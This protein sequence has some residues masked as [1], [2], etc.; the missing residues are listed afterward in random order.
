MGEY[1]TIK[2]GMK[3]KLPTTAAAALQVKH[4]KHDHNDWATAFI[5]TIKG[6]NPYT[7]KLPL[8]TNILR[9]IISKLVVDNSIDSE[10][11]F[12]TFSKY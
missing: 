11:E 3:R 12:F 6:T 10:I 8:T 2:S 1:S 9:I 4:S 7:G 5:N